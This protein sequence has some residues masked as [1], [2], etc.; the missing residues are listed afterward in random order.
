MK[1]IKMDIP[2][3]ATMIWTSTE[4]LMSFNLEKS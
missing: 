3:M 2:F 1:M 4:R